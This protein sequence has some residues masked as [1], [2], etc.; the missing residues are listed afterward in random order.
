[1]KKVIHDVVRRY[2]IKMQFIHIADG[3][4]SKTAKITKI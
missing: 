4:R 1:M 2:I 3:D